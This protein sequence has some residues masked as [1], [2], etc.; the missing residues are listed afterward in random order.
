MCS[1]CAGGNRSV[2]PTDNG[3]ERSSE[4][5]ESPGPGCHPQRGCETAATEPETG[6]RCCSHHSSD[7]QSTRGLESHCC[8]VDLVLRYRGVPLTKTLGRYHTC[9]AGRS[10]LAHK[11][12]LNQTREYESR[13]AHQGR[14]ASSALSSD[15]T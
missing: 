11:R 5:P 4:F 10:G 12:C 3:S 8:G 13:S 14:C 1:Q 6:K 2:S 15:R 7:L 9:T